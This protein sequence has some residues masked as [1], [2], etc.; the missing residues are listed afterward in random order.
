MRNLILLFFF[1]NVNFYSGQN[2]VPNPSFE[3]TVHCPNAN[4]A[5]TIQAKYWFG[6]YDSVFAYYF[7]ACSSP[8]EFGVPLGEVILVNDQTESPL[9]NAELIKQLQNDIALLKQQVTALQQL[10]AKN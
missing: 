1:F 9:C 8:Q 5:G 3:D 2:L 4:N 6:V 7:N 10:A